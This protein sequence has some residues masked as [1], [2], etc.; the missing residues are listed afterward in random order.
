MSKIRGKEK[1]KGKIKYATSHVF[2]IHFLILQEQ[3]FC[4]SPG[5]PSSCT[6]LLQLL[7][8]VV[9]VCWSFQNKTLPKLN[10]R[11]RTQQTTKPINSTCCTEARIRQGKGGHPTKPVKMGEGGSVDISSSFGEVSTAR[12]KQIWDKFGNPCSKPMLFPII[13]CLYYH[14]KIQ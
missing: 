3:W 4:S 11:W 10:V 6:Q 13:M 14:A 9:P 5:T 7:W 12:A 1:K 8:L 2:L